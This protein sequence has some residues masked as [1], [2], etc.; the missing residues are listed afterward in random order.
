MFSRLERTKPQLAARCRAAFRAAQDRERA[1]QAALRRGEAP[2]EADAPSETESS[3]TTSTSSGAGTPKPKPPSSVAQV[4]VLGADDPMVAA[5]AVPDIL[6]IIIRIGQ[7]TGHVVD[8]DRQRLVAE[9]LARA[10]WTLA[11]L[12]YAEAA[13]LTD[14]ELAKQVSYERTIGPGVFA[15][16][17]DKPA[18]RRG[19]LF[20]YREAMAYAQEHGLPIGE[21]FEVVRVQGELKDDGTLA[22][23]W[24]LK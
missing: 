24:R 19:R 5:A 4:R 14:A 22:P 15:L 7:T 16:A 6:P 2:A 12:Q 3:P 18:V 10:D 17:R 23:F 8:R 20:T 9:A 21:A 13:I 1:R 11:E